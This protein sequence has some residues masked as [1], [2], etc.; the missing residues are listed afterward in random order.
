MRGGGTRAWW[1]FVRSSRLGYK[2]S[3]ECFSRAAIRSARHQK[4]ISVLFPVSL[5]IAKLHCQRH[6]KQDG[7]EDAVRL[8]ICLELSRR[9][10][11][12]L[13]EKRE[14]R[15][16]FWNCERLMMQRPVLI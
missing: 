4:I 1:N 5:V 9:F 16:V 15:Q 13:L 12:E 11:I 14:I 6:F 10:L 3:S 2:R 8:R 7:R